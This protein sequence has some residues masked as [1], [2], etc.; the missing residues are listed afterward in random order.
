M[1]QAGSRALPPRRLIF[2]DLDAA[3][4]AQGNPKEETRKSG[5]RTALTNFGQWLVKQGYLDADPFAP[6][7]ELTE[8][9]IL[10]RKAARREE[11]TDRARQAAPARS[12]G[13]TDSGIGSRTFQTSLS[14]SLCGMRSTDG[15]LVITWDESNWTW[16]QGRPQGN[17]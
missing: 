2:L 6:D 13:D 5:S 14:S 16:K 10:A 8:R 17:S 15:R 7:P 1:D 11:A 3:K 4:T 12:E 9:R